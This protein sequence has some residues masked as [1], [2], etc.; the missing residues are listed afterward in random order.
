MSNSDKKQYRPPDGRVRLSQ[1]VTTFGPGSMID[2]LDHA[3]LVSGLDFWKFDSRKPRVAI[4]EPRLR[5]ALLGRMKAMDLNLAQGASFFA[6]PA[7][8]DGAEGPWNG[9]PVLEFPAWFVCQSCHALSHRRGLELK[10][11]KYRHQC[12]RTTSG[13]C[14]P[15]RF[16]VTCKDGHLDEFPWNWFVHRECPRCDG[17]DL[18]LDEGATG[19]FSELVVRCNACQARRS[20]ADARNIGALRTCEGK[21][22]WLG[23]QARVPCDHPQKFLSRTASDAY[24]S[25]TVS[26]LSIPEKGRVLRQAIEQPVLW[27][28]IKNATEASKV[29]LIRSLVAPVDTALESIT[30]K[31]R[32]DFS[33]E[34]IAE[35]VR[36]I[37][38]AADDPREGLR[39]AEF[40]EFLTAKEEVPGEIPPR[41]AEFFASRWVPPKGTVLPPELADI[42]LVKKLRRVTAQVGFTRLSAPTANLQG[43]YEDEAA[44]SA[45]TLAGD[46]LPAVEIWGEGVLVRFREEA[47]QAWE[48]RPEVVDRGK[49]LLAGYLRRYPEREGKGFLGIRY[50]LLHS[51]SH[52][53]MN[54]ISLECGYAAASLSERIYCAPSTDAVP[55]AGI[56]ILTGSAGSEGTLGGLVDQGRRIHRHLER[57]LK[58]GRLC[59]NDPVCAAHAPVKGDRLDP[60]SRFLDGAACHGCLYVAEPSC[61]RSNSYLDR[62]LVVPTM[63][64]PAN[65]AFFDGISAF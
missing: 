65:L 54:A 20:L 36:A 47:I 9:I 39:T 42:T 8:E 57:A 32:S 6:A 55:M 38:S 22:P 27:P 25:Q 30:G 62:A 51:L 17:S 28:L 7:G 64:N 49:M 18:Y 10:D 35:A 56:L 12:S 58:L 14:V 1:L 31:H 59:S 60:T 24:F 5:E 53:L 2:L 52:L 45:L 23:E 15:I 61:E 29:A 4:D 43:D 41:E 48:A 19:D 26:A 50:Y 3:V 13:V 33:D 37:H 46:W 63:G 16:V 21:R 34:E 40:R 44:L 11:K